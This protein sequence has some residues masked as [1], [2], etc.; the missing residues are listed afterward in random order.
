[1]KKARGA[2]CTASAGYGRTERIWKYSG[3]VGRGGDLGTELYFQIA[4]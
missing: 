2:Y 4:D 3:I 1:M